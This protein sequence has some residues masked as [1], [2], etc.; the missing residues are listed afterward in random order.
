MEGDTPR[1]CGY[2]GLVIVKWFPEMRASLDS[3]SKCAIE[4]RSMISQNNVRSLTSQADLPPSLR[5]KL[6]LNDQ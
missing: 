6:L 2:Q 4:N 1:L 3:N 5:K